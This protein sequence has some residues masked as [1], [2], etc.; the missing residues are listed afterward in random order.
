MSAG[1]GPESSASFRHVCAFVE[2]A[3]C[4]LMKKHANT[5]YLR[6]HGRFHETLRRALWEAQGR[7]HLT[8]L[9]Q[10]KEID[11]CFAVCDAETDFRKFHPV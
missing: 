2:R 1:G 11:G 3:V 6:T 9:L 5:R 8:R 10:R 7:L 4:A